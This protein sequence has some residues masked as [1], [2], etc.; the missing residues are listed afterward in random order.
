MRDGHRYVLF[1]FR[2]WWAAALRQRSGFLIVPPKFP[3][4]RDSRGDGAD[5]RETDRDYWQ[6]G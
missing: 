1:E 2:L 3:N 4:H 5:Q 6:H